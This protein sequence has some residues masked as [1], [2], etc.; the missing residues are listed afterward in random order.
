MLSHHAYLPCPTEIHRE[1]MSLLLNGIFRGAWVAHLVKRL[2]ST[3][4]IILGFWDQASYQ[5]PCS[6]GNLLLPRPLPLH[7][8]HALSLSLSNK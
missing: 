1:A 8:I 7:S 4:I 5:A 2:S 3:E 6:M